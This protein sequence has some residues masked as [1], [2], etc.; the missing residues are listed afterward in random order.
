MSTEIGVGTSSLEDT[1]RAAAVAAE[2]AVK[3]V[4]QSE[5]RLALVF[6]T[7]DYSHSL[8]LEKIRATVATDN[9]IGF[10]VAGVFTGFEVFERGVV[11][12]LI[13]GPGLLFD[14]ACEDG[15]S[16]DQ[17]AAGRI[18]GDRFN[19]LLNDNREHALQLLL[20]DGVTT[21]VSG[22]VDSLFH[23]L[24]A[25]PKYAGG[26]SGCNFN[27]EKNYQFF[28][29]RVL[30]DALV[31]SL[32]RSDKSFGVSAAHGWEPSSSPMIVT[33]AEGNV[34]YEL[35]W[36]PAYDVY[37]DFAGQTEKVD[38]DEIGF[39][40]YS[41][42]HPFG[43][44][45]AK[46]GDGYIVRDPVAR[47]EDGSLTCV[48]EVPVNSVLRIMKGSRDSLLT[49]VCEATEDSLRQL[50]GNRAAGV[51]VFSCVSRYGYLQESF[52]DEIGAIR[53]TVGDDVPVCGCLTFGEIGTIG[54]G[55]PEF[56]NKSVVIC[57]FPE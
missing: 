46:E 41:M 32:I 24:G 56:H 48:G 19:A 40:T 50:E 45:Q 20:P 14:S 36:Q 44:P 37:A 21:T 2:T 17:E 25:R 42:S 38:I 1:C 31:S 35:D 51:L 8:L 5:N 7:D 27:Y 13:Q 49:A 54:G 57:T 33:R 11:V 47:G 55:P 10:T 16:R 30:T 39:E 3:Q 23:S 53:G 52:N 6:A 18:L 22:M 9:I 29:S 12:C 28:G 26:A 34:I 4:S 15:L 43:I